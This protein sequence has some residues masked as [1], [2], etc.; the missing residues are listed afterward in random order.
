MST[1]EEIL[2]G[3]SE[4]SSDTTPSLGLDVQQIA[5]NH[6]PSAEPRVRKGWPKGKPR[7]PRLE[8]SSQATATPDQPGSVAS[9]V[10]LSPIAKEQVSCC[11]KQLIKVVDSRCCSL[12]KRSAM[13]VTQDKGFADELAQEVEMTDTEADTITALSVIVLEKYN[14]LGTYAPEVLLGVAVVGYGYRVHSALGEIK[15]IALTHGLHAQA[16]SSADNGEIGH[17]QK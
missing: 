14:V 16:P 17:R 9:G 7:K 6:P 5:D 12:I 4:K 8:S 3:S 1:S 11:V 2:S 13:R 10:A 15:K